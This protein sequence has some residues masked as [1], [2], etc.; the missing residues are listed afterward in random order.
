MLVDLQQ[1][2]IPL[3]IRKALFEIN[4][5]AN[6]MIISTQTGKSMSFFLLLNNSCIV[7][8]DVETHT[9]KEKKRKHSIIYFFI[10]SII[11]TV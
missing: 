1:N 11:L 3:F 7:V 10:F 2:S 6:D 9:H 4:L 5:S 8:V